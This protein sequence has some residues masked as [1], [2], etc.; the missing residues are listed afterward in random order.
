M[1]VRH[2]QSLHKTDILKPAS[3]VNFL[4]SPG[5][6]LLKNTFPK[7]PSCVYFLICFNEFISSLVSIY[8][9]AYY[10]NVWRSLEGWALVPSVVSSWSAPARKVL[11][12][13]C[14]RNQVNKSSSK[15]PDRKGYYKKVKGSNR[16]ADGPVCCLSSLVWLWEE[17]VYVGTSVPHLRPSIQWSVIDPVVCGWNTVFTGCQTCSW[18]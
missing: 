5:W 16:M 14:F 9:F 18:A 8:L 2:V 17:S 1:I 7:H 12:A 13:L 6:S 10:F 3:T 15:F 4:T 11:P